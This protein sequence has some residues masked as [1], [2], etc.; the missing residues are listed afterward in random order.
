MARKKIKQAFIL[1]AGLGTRL[2][3]LTDALP[4]VML[5]IAPG[6]PLLEHLIELLRDQGIT[7][8][9]INLHYLPETI[10]SYFGDWSAWGVHIAYSDETSTLLETGG[11]LRHAEALLDDEFIFLY[12]D[13]LHF[14]DFSPAIELHAEKQGL[15]TVVLKK[16]SYPQDGEIGEFD[17]ATSRI[18]R[19]HARPHEIVDLHETR[20]VNA[21][22][23]VLSK[24]I[25]AYLSPG[26][27][28]KFD[29][30]V[31]PAAFAAGEALN[32]VPTEEVIIDIGKPEKYVQAKEY[33]KERAAKKKKPRS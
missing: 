24:K 9:V 27:P 11:A 17:P 6:K 23:Y 19:W 28:T 20:M 2:R 31:L 26:V 3:P 4:K 16:S 13:Q 22:L 8:F 21:G 10:T 14:F 1:A 29:G 18:L 30:E 33:Y 25:L 5:P 15:A 32:A 12:G 7:D